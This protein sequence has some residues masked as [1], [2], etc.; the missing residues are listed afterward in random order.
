MVDSGST[1]TVTGNTLSFNKIG[2]KV[3]G[4][5]GGIYQGNTLSE[6]TSLGISVDY[7]ATNNAAITGN[8]YSNN[9]VGDLSASGVIDTTVG[10]N[11]TGGSVYYLHNGLTI[12]EGGGLTIGTG[13]MVKLAQYAAIRVYGTLTA[14][15]VTF[16][17]AEEDQEW[18]SIE[19]YG[20]AGASR[21]AGC[22]VEHAMGY[23]SPYSVVRE[24]VLISGSSPTITD[25]TIRASSA[26]CGIFVYSGGSPELSGNTITG[27]TGVAGFGI[28]VDSGSTPTVTGNTLS[29]NKIGIKVQGG[30]GGIYQGNTLSENTSLGISVDYQ[31]TNNAAITGNTYSNNAVGDLSASGVIDTTVGWNETGGSVYY[32]HNSL[33]I[34]E[35]GGLTIGTGTMVKLAQY[36]AIRV[37]GTLTAEDVT[38]TWAEEDQEWRSIEFY[39]TAGASRLAGC[40][41]EHAMGY[42]S[43]Y[44]VVREAV[45]ISGSSPTI[46]DCTIRA[47]SADCGIFV[48]SGGSP[49]LSGNTITG[50]TGVAG[51]GIL[52][53][54]GSTPTVTG[55]TLSF[56]KIGIKVQGG[57]GG[58]YQGNTLSENTSLGISV[59]YQAT[60]NAAIT[61]NTYSNNAVGDLSASGVIDTTV[62][63]NETGGSVY[64]LHNG[65][66]INEGGGL[67]IGTGTMVK[68]AQ[69]AAIRVYGTLTAEDVTFTWA[70][71]DQEWRSIEF[72][73]TAGA[74]R[75]AGCV[76]EHAMG[77]ASPYSVVREAVL[78]SG[79]SPTITDCTIRASSADCGIFVYS[80]GSPEL[81][82]NTITGMTG[83]AGFGILVDSGST[84]TVTGNTLSFNKI[85]IK[86]QGGSGGI[87]QGNTLSENTSLGISVDYQ[88]TNNAAI[89]GNTYSNNAVGDLSASG[90]ID[91]TVGWNETGGSV[92]YLHNSLTINEGGGLTIGTGTMVKLAQYAAIRVYGTLTAEDV[93]FTWAEEDQEWRSIEFYGT[94]GA[95]RLA[96]CVVEH[97][98]GYAS[99]YSVVREAVLISG[100]SPTITDC[101]IRASSADCGIFVYSGGSPELSGNTITGMTGVA[102]F[103][104]LVDSGS[105]PTV[106]GNTLSFNKIGIKVQGGSGGIYQGNII[107]DN[108]VYGLFNSG[109]TIVSAIDNFWG[110]VSGPL[111]DLD[112]RN[113]GGWYNPGGLG[114]RVSNYVKYSPWVGG[115]NDA[116]SDG[117]PDDWEWTIVDANLNDSIDHPWDILPL[118][119]FDGDGFS[120][121]REFLSLSDPILKHSI[122]ICWGDF[123]REGGVDGKDLSSF[124]AE[125]HRNDCSPSDPCLCDLDDNDLVNS[126]DMLFF[127]EDFGRT[128]CY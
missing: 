53:D 120:N 64:Y 40:V 125:F 94:A 92:Y 126:L 124:A 106:T 68:L 43:P 107:A 59:D 77:Y 35:G 83:V 33:T 115:P 58:I 8:T 112:D 10:W 128:D 123:S 39:G 47:S 21:L 37:Y 57:S 122:P 108:S 86:V 103:G 99:P 65:L 14:E 91:T 36:A 5:S 101:T 42:A 70:E 31:A 48:Y 110:D 9:A 67:T 93:T 85:G 75:L 3:Q 79:S 116:D 119:D 95:S 19:F 89:T 20:T 18:R 109:T 96:G 62:G 73:G 113:S 88:A 52:V 24:A 27:M 11:E 17:W 41:V 76:V 16:T 51:F 29:F 54:S 90:V 114:D 121:L 105:T 12:N 117:M 104:I 102:G 23:A 34:N 46:T 44:S 55:N 74:S 15:D 45:L 4:G 66:T 72:Y 84:P 32:L 81:S 7:Q 22:V 63:W 118:D 111:D 80:G 87:Y 71:E 38:F 127:A 61:G 82:G 49:E 78:I 13:T 2:I 25:C 30:S 26:D 60:N 50:M 6:N 100:S 1:P 56:N 97:A 98:M 28:L 69:Y